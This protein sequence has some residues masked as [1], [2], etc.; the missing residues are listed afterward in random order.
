[1]I[2]IAVACLVVGFVSYDIL[3][4]I[5][6]AGAVERQSPANRITTDA[7]KVT[8]HQVILNLQDVR[9]AEFTN[10]DSMDPL[11]D[12]SNHALEMIPL[13][14]SEI[15]EGDIISYITE[16]GI[17]IHRVI[18]IGIDSEGWFAVTKGDNILF[19]DKEKVRFSQ[20]V[21]VVVAILY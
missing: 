13:F 15:Q 3:M 1:M 11:F 14:P 17:I 8:D 4:Q 9:W 12:Q 2:I 7:I 19:K 20:V 5:G 6:I 18:K 21:G 10:T 16:N